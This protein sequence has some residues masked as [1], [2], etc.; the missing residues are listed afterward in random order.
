MA[1]SEASNELT[2]E[3]NLIGAS[4]KV[5][6]TDLKLLLNSKAHDLKTRTCNTSE[7][8][9]QG[10]SNHC[11]SSAAEAQRDPLSELKPTKR[12]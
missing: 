1:A 11:I 5:F 3:V 8:R 9:K 4:S 12:H 2:R 10:L 7:I 6:A